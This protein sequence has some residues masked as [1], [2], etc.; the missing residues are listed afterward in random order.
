MFT[1]VTIQ[2]ADGGNVALINGDRRLGECRG[3]HG[4]PAPRRIARARPGG[5]GE[6]NAT[7]HYGSRQPVFTGVLLG[8]DEDAL[9]TE[10]E[11]IMAAV[12]GMVSQPR[13]LKWT[14]SDGAQL[15]SLVKLGD[16]LDPAISAASA[17]KYLRYQLVFDREDP[18][19]FAQVEVEVEGDSLE[20][21]GGGMTFPLT[22]PFTFT[23]TSGGQ[24][25]IVD[26]G[27]IGT[28]PVYEI[29]G[30]IVMPTIRIVDT[31]EDIVLDVE[32][33]ADDYIEIDVANRTVL[34]G[35]TTHREDLVDFNLTTWAD[36]PP[37]SST[38][39]LLGAS[40]DTNAHLVVRYRAAYP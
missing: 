10:Y 18:R 24:A 8:D 19:N 36:L 12:W 33:A 22:F 2:E 11:A 30:G 26:A 28:S 40:F 1:S 15:Q 23:T 29:H 34:L 37:G 17:G 32:V 4:A 21:L 38:V 14:R 13:L 27:P 31:M 9:W 5:H 16:A 35:G 39:Q 20:E 3:L 7:R 25:A 6:I